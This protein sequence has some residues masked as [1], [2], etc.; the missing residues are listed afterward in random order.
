[1]RRAGAEEHAVV[2]RIQVTQ[3]PVP[4]ER[5]TEHTQRYRVLDDVSP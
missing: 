5:I 4:E 1:M 2:R 3:T